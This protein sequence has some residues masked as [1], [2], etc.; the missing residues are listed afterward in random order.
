[1][2]AD[3]FVLPEDWKVTGNL[4][5]GLDL[6]QTSGSYENA[7][8]VKSAEHY[9]V[10]PENPL[11]MSDYSLVKSGWPYKDEEEYR[12][13]HGLAVEQGL[14]KDIEAYDGASDA[15][16]TLSDR[17]VDI[18]VITSRFVNHRQNARVVIDTAHWL[19][20]NNIPYRELSF[21]SNKVGVFADI[22][23]DDSPHNIESLTAAGRTVI[24]YDALYNRQFDGPRAHNWND[25]LRL[26]HDIEVSRHQ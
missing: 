14:Y 4:T 13:M 7:L 6:D 20:A 17:G 3:E 21:T 2:S 22:Y 25:V 5:L 26:V 10:D 24:I 23:I 8:W 11:P 16:W 9:N 15:L 19:D 12:K 1:M 18:H